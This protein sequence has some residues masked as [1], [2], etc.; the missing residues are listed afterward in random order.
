MKTRIVKIL[1]WLAI[2]LGALLGLVVISLAIVIW[3]RPWFPFMDD[4]PFKGEPVNQLPSRSPDQVYFLNR[5]KLEIFN[6]AQ[7]QKAPI[8]VLR[9]SDDQ[10][11]WSIYA[12][13]MNNTEVQSIE[14]IDHR[15]I[16]STTVRGTVKWTYG[17]EA[18]WWY[19]S[20]DGELEEYWY[21]W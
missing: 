16:L 11:Q 20:R 1:K 5:Y 4:G 12:T 3:Q 19:V 2:S 7:N 18:T 9:D 13:G 8:V 14:F 21:S 10:E 15:T 17:N 6:R